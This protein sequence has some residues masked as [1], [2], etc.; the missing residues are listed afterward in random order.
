MTLYMF[1]ARNFDLPKPLSNDFDGPQTYAKEYQ[2][3]IYSF[4]DFSSV[5]LCE[6]QRSLSKE[7]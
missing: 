5:S 7:I 1:Y 6:N 4:L 3:N 2:G